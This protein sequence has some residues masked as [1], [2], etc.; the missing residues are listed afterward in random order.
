MVVGT[1]VQTP[2]GLVDIEDIK[3]GDL[4]LAYDEQTGQLHAEPV[5][6]LIRPNPQLT[7]AVTLEDHDHLRDVFRASADHPW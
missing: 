7:F 3:L 2:N 5:T 6:A 4:V 1:E